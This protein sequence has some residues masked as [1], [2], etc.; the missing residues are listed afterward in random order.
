MS[1][2]GRSVSACTPRARCDRRRLAGRLW[3]NIG[4][5]SNYRAAPAKPSSFSQEERGHRRL[6]GEI[7]IMLQAPVVSNNLTSGEQND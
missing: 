4:A 1:S 5:R 7:M 6:C 3:I 2:A